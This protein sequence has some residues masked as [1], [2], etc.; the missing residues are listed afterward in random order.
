LLP[1]PAV[2]EDVF[3]RI[4]RELVRHA[5]AAGTARRVA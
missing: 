1:E 2:L 3:V 4:E 5:E